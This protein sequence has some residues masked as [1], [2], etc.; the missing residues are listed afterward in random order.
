MIEQIAQGASASTSQGDRTTAML[1][2]IVFVFLITEL[3]AGVLTIA[4]STSGVQI[5]RVC[6]N[7]FLYAEEGNQ[8]YMEFGEIADLLALINNSVNFILYCTMSA[9]FR[10]E[11]YALFCAPVYKRLQVS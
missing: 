8:F 5:M 1:I 10:E 7:I 2:A 4:A 11:F 9:K 3:P 6:V